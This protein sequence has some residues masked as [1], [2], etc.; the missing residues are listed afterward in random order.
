MKQYLTKNKL[1]LALT[2]LLNVIYAAAAVFIA[3]FLQRIIDAAMS[4]DRSAFFRVLV[5]SVIYLVL[6]G[7]L[8]YAYS[9][10]SKRLVRNLTIL[11]RQKAF[12]GIFRRNTPDFGSVN[13]SDYISAFTNDINLIEVNYI[14][15]LLLI[16]QYGVIFIVSLILLFEINPL[17]TLIL[18]G[19]VI[20]ML[21]IPGLLGK[22]LQ[23]RQDRLSK[24]LSLFTRKLLKMCPK[25]EA[26]S[27]SLIA[28]TSLL[29][30]LIHPLPEA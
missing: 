10:S 21:L 2:L 3:K 5:T 29:N 15:P 22:S 18:A 8:S 20:F 6:L 30:I 24:Q 23:T 11:L 13:T 25:S 9:L 26:S 14:T 19:C 27:P 12:Q 16:V 17:I 7:Y 1:L 4:G 28:S